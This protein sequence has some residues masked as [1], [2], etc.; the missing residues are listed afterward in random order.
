MA[1]PQSFLFFVI[2]IEVVRQ[3]ILVRSVVLA[4]GTGET[5]LNLTSAHI[6]LEHVM[7]EP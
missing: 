1:H 3:V 4:D 2:H 6:V 7:V 5:S